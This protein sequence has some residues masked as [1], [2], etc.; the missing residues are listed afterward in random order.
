MA[1]GFVYF[2]MIS[3]ICMSQAFALNAKRSFLQRSTLSRTSLF[4]TL[5]PS[6]TATPK[7][8]LGADEIIKNS[9]VFIFDCDGVIWKGDS[10]IPGV[11]AVLDKLRAQ[12]KMIFFVTN[13]STKSR[14]GYLKKFTGLGLN[15]DA[16]GYHTWIPYTCYTNNLTYIHAIT[17][18]LRN[19]YRNLL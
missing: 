15:V 2:I 18:Y 9:D 1:R 13:N 12:G 3:L 4:S 7:K 11:P 8:I 17:V 10:L 5:T 14:K 19:T 16:K 6:M